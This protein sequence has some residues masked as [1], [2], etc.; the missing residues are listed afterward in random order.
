MSSKTS[1]LSKKK[2]RSIWFNFYMKLILIGIVCLWGWS[3]DP[4]RQ[5]VS[6]LLYKA[7]DAVEPG[8]SKTNKQTIGERIDSFMGN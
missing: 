7:A 8:T 1:Q 2:L 6:E 4:T 3:H 5:F